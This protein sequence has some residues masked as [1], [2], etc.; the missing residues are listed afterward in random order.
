M[1]LEDTR[2]AL[3]RNALSWLRRCGYIALACLCFLLVSTKYTA[4]QVDEGSI[5]GT[6]TDTTG[7]VVPNATVTLLNTDVGLSL[8]NRTN[9]NGEYTFS[10]VRVGNY[11][12][13]VTAQGF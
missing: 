4:A 5:T 11:S 2:M 3:D 6:V 10:P 1:K 12:I 8:T 9:S 7:A 13:T